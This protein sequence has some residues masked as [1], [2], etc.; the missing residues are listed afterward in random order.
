VSGTSSADTVFQQ[1][2][3]ELESRAN[4][5]NVEGMRRFGISSKGTLGVTMPEVRSLASGAQAALGRDPAKLHG[6]ATLLWESGVHEARIMAAVLDVPA[7]VPR[8]QAEAWALDVDSWDTCDQLCGNLL[9]RTAFAWE[10]PGDWASREEVF[11]KRAGFVV[12]TQLAVKDKKASDDHLIALLPLVEREARDPRNDVKKGVN[13]AL[14]QIGKRSPAC[15]AAALL[16]AE[17]ILASVPKRGGT[18]G[19]AAARWIAR[20]ALRELKSEAVGRRLGLL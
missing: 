10:L 19:E 3:R 9:W 6:L 20:D 2:L 1:L 16:S 8:D 15:H 17:R 13:W 11:V 14:R 4:P 5:E 12:A 7:L 18:P